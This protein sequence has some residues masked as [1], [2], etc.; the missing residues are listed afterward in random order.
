[1]VRTYRPSRGTRAKLRLHWFYR[2]RDVKRWQS[3]RYIYD[4]DGKIVFTAFEGEIPYCTWNRRQ[5][6]DKLQNV[7]TG[8][9]NEAAY[10]VE[11]FSVVQKIVRS[12]DLPN[13]IW[14]WAGQINGIE[15]IW[16]LF[17]YLIRTIGLKQLVCVHVSTVTNTVAC[18]YFL[19]PLYIH[20]ISK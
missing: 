8:W 13:G 4:F 14:F 3:K 5:A 2:R 15:V 10:I 11:S 19:Q 16:N 18:K 7:E 17:E 9:S 6:E 1:M 12:W 20:R